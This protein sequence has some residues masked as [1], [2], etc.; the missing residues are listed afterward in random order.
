MSLK[1]VADAG[2]IAEE[3]ISSVRTV[4]AF[5][6]QQTLSGLYDAHIGKSS[7]A[8]VKGALW[9]GGGMSVMFFF[10]YSSYALGRF[11]FRSPHIL[12]SSCYSLLFRNYAH[13]RKTWFA[14]IFS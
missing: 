6:T 14:H 13:L 9:W 4:Q 11:F 5:G 12:D 3:V 2:N 8:E 1:H 10:I 7:A